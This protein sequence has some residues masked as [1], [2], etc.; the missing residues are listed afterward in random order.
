VL[1]QHAFTCAE[2]TRIIGVLKQHAFTC[3]ETTR[4]MGVLKQHTFGYGML[5]QHAFLSTKLHEYAFCIIWLKN[6]LIR[7]YT[8]SNLVPRAFP[9]LSLGRREKTLAPGG[10][11]CILIGQ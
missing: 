4:L 3:A 8:I 2:T 10:L 6:T 7:K 11:L 9:F 5:K 1:K